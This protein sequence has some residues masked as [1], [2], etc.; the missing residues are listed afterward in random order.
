MTDLGHCRFNITDEMEAFYDMEALQG[1]ERGSNLDERTMRL[2]SGKLLGHRSYSDQNANRRQREK[3]PGQSG[4][5]ST[6]GQHSGAISQAL[7]TRKD[8]KEASLTT[9]LSGLSKE[10][11]MS[12]AHLP[13]SDQRSLLVHHKKNLDK[14]KRAERKNRRKLDKV[15]DKIAVHCNYYKQ[16]VPI[17]S[18]G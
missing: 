17:Y 7:T 14:A 2:P 13:A 8:R 9:Q 3:S 12:L 10:D 15:G 4:L 18:G 5:P 16:E 11:Q 1:T 6:G